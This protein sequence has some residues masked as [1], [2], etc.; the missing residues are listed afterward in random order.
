MAAICATNALNLRWT[1]KYLCGAIYEGEFACMFVSVCLYVCV[2]QVKMLL[3][4]RYLA[5]SESKRSTK[6]TQVYLRLWSI[7]LAHFGIAADIARAGFCVLPLRFAFHL[8]HC[9]TVALFL[10]KQTTL[11]RTFIYFTFFC[12][13]CCNN[14][15]ST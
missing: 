15:P 14:F 6:R 12:F 7:L 13:P 1:A 3:I 2:A 10:S 5:A 4:S 8:L 9:F 11:P